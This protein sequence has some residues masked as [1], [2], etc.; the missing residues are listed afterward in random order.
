MMSTSTTIPGK[1]YKYEPNNDYS[2]Q[3]LEN[4]QIYFPKPSELNDP[5]DCNVPINFTDSTIEELEEIY[6][7]LSEGL[8]EKEVIS[9]QYLSNGKP[10]KELQKDIHSLAKKVELKKQEY[11]NKIG[12]ACFSESPSSKPDNILLWS[13]Y[14]DGHKGFCLEFDTCYFPFTGLVIPLQ[15]VNYEPEFP[16]TNSA[17]AVKGGEVWLIPLTTKS[18]EWF[19]EH[20]WRLIFGKGSLICFYEPE[21]LTAIYFGC[22]MPSEEKQKIAEKLDGSP[23]KCYEMRISKT[24]Y[25]LEIEKYNP[26]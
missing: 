15:K 12:V 21:A 22:L 1:L 13:H 8:A 6:Q 4:R 25:T 26:T 14:A 5:Y 9:K 3:N 24:T 16:S 17:S 23:T 10:N 7:M 20:E 19:Y 18:D 2:N 11:F